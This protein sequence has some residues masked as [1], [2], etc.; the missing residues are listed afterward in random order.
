MV[1]RIL[2]TTYISHPIETGFLANLLTIGYVFVLVMTSCV[3]VYEHHIRG[4]Q[5]EHFYKIITDRCTPLIPSTTVRSPHLYKEMTARS[6][7]LEHL[8]VLQTPAMRYWSSDNMLHSWENMRPVQWWQRRYD[9]VVG[10]VED[11]RCFQLCWSSRR[12]DLWSAPAHSTP[13][14]HGSGLDTGKGHSVW[15]SQQYFLRTLTQKYF[16]NP[17][18]TPR[19]IIIFLHNVMSIMISW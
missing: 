3:W 2:P 16:S 19:T 6:W 18:C 7:K 8:P 11:R 4:S 12:C 5:V 14:P 15:W 10:Q 13:H 9:C 17:N 1:R